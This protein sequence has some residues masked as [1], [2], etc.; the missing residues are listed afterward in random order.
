MF[1]KFFNVWP[2]EYS[3]LRPDSQGFRPFVLKSLTHFG[4]FLLS[5]KRNKA[6]EKWVCPMNFAFDLKYFLFHGINILINLSEVVLS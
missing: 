6:K 3:P 2:N 5:K 4:I 1:L